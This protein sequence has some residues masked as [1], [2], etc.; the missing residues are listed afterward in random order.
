MSPQLMEACQILKY[1]FKHK[2][3]LDFTGYLKDKAMLQEMQMQNLKDNEMPEDISAKDYISRFHP[4][5]ER[6]QRPQAS[7]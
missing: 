6:P 3:G 2:D 5:G 4:L 1:G 7:E